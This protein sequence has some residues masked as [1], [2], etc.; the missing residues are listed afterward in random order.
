MFKEN[1]NIRDSM[2]SLWS[3]IRMNNLYLKS[4][5]S[6]KW[7]F[8]LYWVAFKF[9]DIPLHCYQNGKEW[10]ILLLHCTGNLKLRF[11]E[12]YEVAHNFMENIQNYGGHSKNN[13][14]TTNTATI[15]L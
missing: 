1:D 14:E 11:E 8:C 7:R 2:V 10:T 3:T 15:I 9:K 5:T 6:V 12:N 4:K 13:T